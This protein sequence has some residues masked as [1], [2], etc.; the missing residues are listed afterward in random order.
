MNIFVRIEVLA[1]ELQGRL[2]LSLAAAERGHQVVLLDKRSA[3]R[4][5]EHPERLPVSYFH[6]NSPGQHSGK[7]S[8][9]E[10]LAAQ[11][12]L[13]TGQDEEHGLTTDDFQADMG[14]RF[15]QRGM[16][17]KCAMFGFGPF[18]AEGIRRACPDYGDRVFV[19]GSPRV[20]FWRKDLTGRTPPSAPDDY[21]LFLMSS[22]PFSAEGPRISFNEA[23]GSRV[24][25]MRRIDGLVTEG[26]DATFV[27]GY[28]RVVDTKLA[29]EDIARRHPSIIVVYR[30]HPHE[31]LSAWEQVFADAP[32][33]VRV[34]RDNAV[35]PWVRHARC[36]VFGGSTVGFEAAFAGVPLISFQ[37]E[38]HDATP[39]ANRMGHRA[40][41]VAEVTSIVDAILRGEEPAL[42][43]ERAAAMQETLSS[44]FFAME[45]RLAADRIVDVWEELATDGVRAARQISARD[46]RPRPSPRTLA[47]SVRDALA[48][49]LRLERP[50]RRAQRRAD[51]DLL[52]LKFPAFDLEEVKSI[53]QSL[54]EDLGRFSDIRITRV[55]AR[56]L[57]LAR[58]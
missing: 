33:N 47:R 54:V 53:Q 45:G 20:D 41:S 3:Y 4:L 8:L 25:L 27:A 38:G 31:L 44:R 36:V 21:L 43:T 22:S 52:E 35:S 26:M 10:G 39:A 42:D 7:T 17:N 12:W 34:I 23:G 19:T 48:V 30:P 2:L 13:I 46:L 6:D 11:G 24:D 58:D 28:R 37:P 32:S 1:R 50:D 55:G 16:A 9:H 18:D 29:V 15:P 14:H 56:V 40:T 57:H 49:A 51:R 5:L